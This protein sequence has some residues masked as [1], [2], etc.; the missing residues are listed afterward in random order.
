MADDLPVLIFVGNLAPSTTEDQLYDTFDKCGKVLSVKIPIHPRTREPKQVAYVQYETSEAF[1]R[2][3]NELNGYPINGRAIRVS[4]ARYISEK[5]VYPPARER[6]SKEISPE[7]RNDYVHHEHRSYDDKSDD[8]RP[9]ER[10]DVPR[11]S[12]R[13][14]ERR[15]YDD[16]D[17]YDRN[18][19]DST[20]PLDDDRVR[21][22][23]RDVRPVGEDDLLR[24]FLSEK[25][26]ASKMGIEILIEKELERRKSR[27]I[28]ELKALTD[29][30]LREY[31]RKLRMQ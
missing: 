24:Q 10:Y 19:R 29:E 1:Q 22:L 20:F 7:R 13:S 21:R 5:P 3:L 25:S 16:R 9:R 11:D 30:E 28:E 27:M 26:L 23:A 12:K 4:Q 18:Y 8:R 17:G 15:R 14:D 6:Q 2:C 31:H